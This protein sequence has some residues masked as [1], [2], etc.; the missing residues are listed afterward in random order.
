MRIIRSTG[1][2]DEASPFEIRAVGGSLVAEVGA[3]VVQVERRSARTG[4]ESGDAFI[5][6]QKAAGLGA[7]RSQRHQHHALVG[8]RGV[9]QRPQDKRQVKLNIHFYRRAGLKHLPNHIGGNV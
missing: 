1:K 2:L 7:N 6:G 4:V 3:V 5:D 8:Q 9:Q